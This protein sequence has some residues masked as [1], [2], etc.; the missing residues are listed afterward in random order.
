[1]TQPKTPPLKPHRIS[2]RLT[3]DQ[4]RIVKAMGGPQKAFD[5]LFKLYLEATEAGN[6][7]YKDYMKDEILD[8]DLE[9]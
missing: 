9:L 8:K 3:M 5:K 1:M 2:L 6:Q 4:I 7:A